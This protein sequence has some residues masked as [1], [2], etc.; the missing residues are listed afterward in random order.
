M[1]SA[2]LGDGR[3]YPVAA[4]EAG[5]RLV[6]QLVYLLGRQLVDGPVVDTSS[7]DQGDLL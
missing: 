6:E 4:D 7:Y 1:C 2:L 3:V 5:L